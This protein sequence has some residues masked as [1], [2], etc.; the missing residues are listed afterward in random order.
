MQW[1]L[2][3]HCP[4]V[5]ECL[6]VFFFFS[7][8]SDCEC[9]I[10]TSLTICQEMFDCPTVFNNHCHTTCIVS[11]VMA[12]LVLFGHYLMIVRAI[13]SHHCQSVIECFLFVLSLSDC[14]CDIVTPLSIIS[15]GMFSFVLSLSNCERNIVTSLSIICHGMFSFFLGVSD[16]PCNIIPQLPIISHGMFS[17]VLSLSD[18]PCNN[19]CHIIVHHLSWNV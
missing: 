10:V 12:C 11:S 1:L 3:H 16:C 8:L 9:N 2:P 6:V 4:S 15:H 19:Y 13:F 14:P 18:C 7:W 17:F 5:M